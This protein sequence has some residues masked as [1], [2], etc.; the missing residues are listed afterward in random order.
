MNY[1]DKEL[2]LYNDYMNM[3]RNM[4]NEQGSYLTPKARKNML[5]GNT[6]HKID[7]STWCLIAN[8]QT[9]KFMSFDLYNKII[10]REEKLTQLGL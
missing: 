1:T 5:D 8:K 10:I 6:L 7:N 2:E 9:F 3:V 4:I